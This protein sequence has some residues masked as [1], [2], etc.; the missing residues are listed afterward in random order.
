MLE[1]YLSILVLLREN[2]FSQLVQTIEDQVFQR[3]NSDQFSNRLRP[4]LANRNTEGEPYTDF[5]EQPASVTQIKKVFNALYH[6]RMA[7]I[8]VES[9]DIP[10]ASKI[11]TR[12]GDVNTLYRS[13]LSHIAEAGR[14]ATHLDIDFF[15]IFSQELA[16]LAPIFTLISTH[17]KGYRDKT[18]G[19]LTQMGFDSVAHKAGLFSGIAL[20]QLDLQNGEPDYEFLAWFGAVIPGYLDKFTSFIEQLSSNVVERAPNVD[21]ERLDELQDH[22]LRLL[23]ALEGARSNGVFLPLQALHYIHV[24]RHTITLSV[25]IFEQVGHLN[26]AT[27][28]TARIK[29]AELKALLA[30]GLGFIDKIEEHAMLKPGILSRPQLNKLSQTYKV[31]ATYTEKFVDFSSEGKELR[32]LEDAKFIEQ[33]L[34]WAY[35]RLAIEKKGLLLLDNVEEAA[36]QF[37]TILRAHENLR[38]LDISLESRQL[39]ITHYKILQPYVLQLDVSLNKAIVSALH[40]NRSALDMPYAKIVRVAVN[41]AGDR[42]HSRNVLGIEQSLRACFAKRRAS[43]QFHINLSTDIID[44]VSRDAQNLQLFPYS[45]N[46][47]ARVDEKAVLDKAVQEQLRFEMV[48][49]NNQITNLQDLNAEQIDVLYN[50]YQ[51]KLANLEN[52]QRTYREF[53]QTLQEEIPAEAALEN[54]KER[55]RKLGSLYRGFQSYLLKPVEPTVVDEENVALLALDMQL[56]AAFSTLEQVDLP[57]IHETLKPLQTRLEGMRESLYARMLPYER[58]MKKMALTAA[59]KKE[60]VLESNPDRPYHVLKHKEFSQAVSKLRTYLDKQ[61]LDK[62]LPTFN[63][64]LRAQLKVSSVSGEP[65]FPELQDTNI[66]LEQSTQVSLIKQVFNSLFYLEHVFL[67]LEEINDQ[68]WQTQSAIHIIT[69]AGKV[70]KAVVI[71]QNLSKIPYIKN[72]VDDVLQKFEAI[73]PTLVSLQEKYAP[74]TTLTEPGLPAVTNSPIFYAMNAMIF[75]PEHIKAVRQ[76]EPLNAPQGQTLHTYAEQVTIDLERIIKKSGSYLALSTEVLTMYRLFRD[77]KAKL[78][79]LVNTTY[80]IAIVSK[81]LSVINEEIITA[82]LL[83]L[84]RWE[85]ACCLEPGSLTQPVKNMFDDYYKGLLEPLKLDSQECVTLVSSVYSIEKRQQEVKKRQ[86][87]AE[88]QL[89]IAKEHQT[90]LKNLKNAIKA[91]EDT[92]EEELLAIQKAT[93]K[94]CFTAALRLLRQYQPELSS[95][96]PL[97]SDRT[98]A[99]DNMIQEGVNHEE[100]LTNIAALTGASFHRHKGVCSTYQLAL[101][102]ANGKLTFLHDLMAA[103]PGLREKYKELYTLNNLRRKK[104]IALAALRVDLVDPQLRKEYVTALKKWLQD[105]EAGMVAQAKTEVNIDTKLDQLLQE[106]VN[107]FT[108]EHNRN[109]CHL[110]KIKMVVTQMRN[111]VDTTHLS[112]SNRTLKN[113]HDQVVILENLCTQEFNND[114]I[115]YGLLKLTTDP[116]QTPFSEI[117]KAVKLKN[118][119]LLFGNELYYVDMLKEDISKLI[120][121]VDKQAQ[122][123]QLKEAFTDGYITTNQVECSLVNSIMNKTPVISHRIENIQHY[124]D[125]NKYT[126][127]NTMCTYHRH[128]FLTLA[129]VKQC[130]QWL[131]ELVFNPERKTNYRQLIE[132]AKT[133]PTEESQQNWWPNF[134]ASQRRYS[135]P[136]FERGVNIEPANPLMPVA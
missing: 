21:K 38:I 25:N 60:F 63:A 18:R 39:L 75:L 71:L 67:T 103:Q 62:Q 124:L 114:F 48:R 111:Y 40:G 42:D 6:G 27:Q 82:I 11:L 61:L 115:Q 110:D 136:G 56:I 22:A 121:P 66:L 58:L 46:E 91:Y 94:R 128:N 79:D 107:A 76:N 74:A 134:F 101:E 73:K 30:T 133:P 98:Q 24:I 99:F 14:L 8:D 51:T 118:V 2:R 52:A 10:H 9:V 113:K 123:T 12:V 81:K 47:L 23:N 33:R 78:V 122:F 108:K 93:L 131:Y 5:E 37:F 3:L 68:D 96:L 109:Y 20:D 44:H 15:D 50:F 32:T 90:T 59:Q 106:S 57:N 116:L 117:K 120:I 49:G 72:L 26:E 112:E 80:D 132:T 64:A 53:L 4:F 88:D 100:S 65:P 69:I 92:T 43:H 77:L 17:F 54:I 89:A 31:V 125:T 86:K 1:Q 84:D 36:T 34:G 70:V 35:Q 7:L 104:A 127:K 102:T 45:A 13:T 129:W 105:A 95:S 28:N 126:F 41:R 130:V 97:M 87:Q 55:K 29:L 119:V 135:V 16:A 19:M 85:D 83:E